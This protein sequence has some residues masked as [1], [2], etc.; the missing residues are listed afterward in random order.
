MGKERKRKGQVREAQ[1]L[2]QTEPYTSRVESKRRKED[3][4][5]LALRCVATEDERRKRGKQYER[6]RQRG[7]RNVGLLSETSRKKKKKKEGRTQKTWEQVRGK[8][9]KEKRIGVRCVL[10]FL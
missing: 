1:E 3:Q 5:R 8:K 6:T 4:T 9:E 10:L 2:K 7:R